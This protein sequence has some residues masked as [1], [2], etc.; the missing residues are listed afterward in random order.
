MSSARSYRQF[1]GIAKALDVVGERW[2]LLILRDLLLGPRRFSDLEHG[3]PGITPNLL[4]ERLKRLTE[5]GVITRVSQPPPAGG[6][7]Y[8]L[9]EDGLGLEPALL[10]LGRWGWRSMQKK[11]KREDVLNLGWALI[12]L[13]RRF[14]GVAA[15][16]TV[17]LRT[18]ERVYQYR[19]T[20]DYPDVREGRPWLA[21][22]NVSGRM[23]AFRALFFGLESAEAL[24]DRS[25]LQLSGLVERWPD[26]LRAFGIAEQ[27]DATA[28]AIG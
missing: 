22:L 27:L 3:L 9:T 11:P 16:L 20:A 18:P 13:K 21:E 12:A 24:L 25:A 26:F 1:C 17:E 8:E 2:T 14:V 10:A 23:E 7:A 15:T 19:L 6:F 5:E 28:A 4:T